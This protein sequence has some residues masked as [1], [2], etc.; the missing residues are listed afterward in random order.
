MQ[1]DCLVGDT[2]CLWEPPSAE[3]VYTYNRHVPALR[4][5]ALQ[6]AFELLSSDIGIAPEKFWKAFDSCNCGRYFTKEA[7]HYN[8]GPLCPQWPYMDVPHDT[9]S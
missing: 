2:S 5:P 7:L 8:H 1:G 9:E 4:G 3:Q 6:E